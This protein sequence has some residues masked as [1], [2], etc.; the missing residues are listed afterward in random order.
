MVGL[1]SVVGAMSGPG[2]SIGVSVF[3]EPMAMDLGTSDAV[4]STA[5]LVGT[6]AASMMLP[7][8]GRWVDEVGV[9]RALT[10]VVSAFAFA[11]VHM[12]VIRHV[13]WLAVGF[14]GIRLLGQGAMS[15][16]A[17][18]SVS[19][20]F[21][22]RRG[23]ALGLSM[24]GAAAGMAVVPLLLSIGISVWGWRLTWVVTGVVVF[25]LVLAIARFGL[26]D[27]PAELG[28]VPD[29][30]DLEQPRA[31]EEIGWSPSR[32]EILRSRAFRVMAAVV[33]A[34]SLL[35]T[36]MVFHQTNVLGELGYSS[37][38]AAAMFL[39]QAVG[40][41][42]GG[43][44][45]GWAS[46]RPFRYF[47]PAIVSLLLALSCLLG[48]VGST[49][50]TVFGYSVGVGIC[51]GGGAAVNSALLPRLFGLRGLGAV[52]GMLHMVI[53][54]NSAF[55]ALVLS[56]GANIFGSYRGALAALTLWP[57]VLAVIVSI[58]RPQ[59]LIHQS[60]ESSSS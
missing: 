12:S 44:A 14:F 38:R 11:L 51:T 60:A 3:R 41:I 17:Q 20:W 16:V 24:T 54:V 19:H 6:L 22:R 2:Q 48:G 13:S 4:V 59:P 18:V 15:L 50:A 7:R 45:F 46:D 5:Y 58:W 21:E 9:R 47:L 35:I 1:A 29:G 26:V 27:R 39:P 56:V 25:V 8:V 37:A 52:T 30:A 43:L 28:Q 34:N 53:V 31:P 40:A 33:S 23:M 36:G 55:A 10:V 32:S 42:G 49:T 57:A